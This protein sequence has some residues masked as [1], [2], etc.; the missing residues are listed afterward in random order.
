M[1]GVI[2]LS[3]FIA[4][5]P[6]D[7]YPAHDFWKTSPSMFFIRLGG[8][9]AIAGIMFLM[10]RFLKSPWRVPLILGKESLFIYIAH[11]VVVYGSVFNQ[12]L[13][14]I[15]GPTLGVPQTLAVFGVVLVALS[16]ATML[17]YALKSRHETVAA[18][19]RISGIS[20]FIFEFLT[21]RW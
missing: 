11:L 12:G 16:L 3:W 10:E 7:I 8:V 1:W 14:Q 17:W 20:I 18:W 4:N 9:N 5:R 2:L 15:T 13:S 21:R 19:I 6:F